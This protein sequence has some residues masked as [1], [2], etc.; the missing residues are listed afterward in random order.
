MAKH[1]DKNIEIEITPLTNLDDYK[2]KYSRQQPIK[3]NCEKCGK[4]E[5]RQFG[6]FWHRTS[7]LCHDCLLRELAEYYYQDFPLESYQISTI[8]KPI[9]GTQKIHF[10]CDICGNK[11]IIQYRHYNGNICEHCKRSKSATEL[12]NKDG[13]KEY[14]KKCVKEKTGFDCVFQNKELMRTAWERKYGPG[15]TG[16]MQISEFQQKQEK[17]MEKLYG[18]YTLASKELREKVDATVESLYGAKNIRNTQYY[19]ELFETFKDNLYKNLKRMYLYDGQYFDSSWELAY[20]IWLKDNNIVFSYHPKPGITYFSNGKKH[21]YY[22]DF[23]VDN[24]I[25]EI[26]GDQFFDTNGNYITNDDL[27]MSKYKC[28]IDNHVILYRKTDILKYLEYVYKKYG[29]NY[30]KQFK[31]F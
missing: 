1:L 6:I 3:F 29:K 20:Y 7:L 30:L 4:V 22:P 27:S 19:L 12:W 9:A 25:I 23:I 15:I 31:Q 5:H 2:I 24:N 26:K 16:A 17:T 18:G 11:D 21:T 10:T 8:N 13:Y 14:H 28:M